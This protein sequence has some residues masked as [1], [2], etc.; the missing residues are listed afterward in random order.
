MSAW[1]KWRTKDPL[2]LYD[3][4]REKAVVDAGL[5]TDVCNKLA[6]DVVK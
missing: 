5:W 2:K 4:N 6:A 3:Q 1:T